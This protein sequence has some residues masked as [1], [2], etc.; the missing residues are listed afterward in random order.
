MRLFDSQ[1]PFLMKTKK[2]I[3]MLQMFLLIYASSNATTISLLEAYKK[4]WIEFGVD[5]RPETYN[6]KALS[7]WVKNN[8][9][10]TLDIEI[11]PALI[12]QPNDTAYQDLVVLGFQKIT[13]P[14]KSIQKISLQT[15]CAKEEALS[16]SHDLKFNYKNQG[17][18]N[19]IAVFDFLKKRQVDNSLAQWAV[20]FITGKKNSLASVYSSTHAKLSVELQQLLSK[21]YKVEM[22]L[23]FMEKELN[24]GTRVRPTAPKVLKLH[25]KMNWEQ[26]QAEY[27][28]ISIFN[29]ENKEVYTYLK[30]K[31]LE[32]GFHEIQASFQ[33]FTYPAGNYWVRVYNKELDV[34]KEVKVHL[35]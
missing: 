4:K 9:K 2:I 30:D 11:D 3:L 27:V 22:P 23:F 31:R 35:E 19:M 28:S 33:T 1:N 10:T 8:H 32:P 18:S 34:L 13:V 26:N 6:S 20:W 24:G 16:P 12:F 5:K 17:D 7:L 14:P 15:Y 21:R 25:V 29:E